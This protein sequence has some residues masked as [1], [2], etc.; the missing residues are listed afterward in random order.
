MDEKGNTCPIIWKSKL[1]RRG[2]GSTLAAE[3]AGI[4]EAVEWAK[5]IKF[6][7]MEI[8]EE[9]EVPHHSVY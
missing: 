4:I 2:I 9:G 3:V 1:A 7:W 8:I 6:L 5:Y